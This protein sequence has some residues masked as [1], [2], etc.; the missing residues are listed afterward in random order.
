MDRVKQQLEQLRGQLSGLTPS[1]RMLVGTLLAVIA[2]TV[3]W[4]VRHAADGEMM[5]LLDQPLTADQAGVIR[6]HLRGEGI[7]FQEV[8]GKI[9]VP[10]T[11]HAEAMGVVSFNR[12][13]PSD[14]TQHFAKAL[15]Q[16]GSF[17]PRA[18]IDGTLLHA[19]ERSLAATIGRWPGVRQVEVHLNANYKRQIGGD[20]LPTAGVNVTSDGSLD[21]RSRVADAAA[22]MIAGAIPM[23]KPSAV[24]VII[25]GMAVDTNSDDGLAGGSRLLALKEQA[26][27]AWEQRLRQHYQ[28][29]PQL[30]VTVNVEVDDQVKRSTATTIDPE[31]KLIVPLETRTESDTTESASADAGGEG[32]FVPNAVLGM[33]ATAVAA[34]GGSTSRDVEETTNHVEVGR[35]RMETFSKGGQARPVSCSLSLPLSYVTQ[36][37]QGR[38]PSAGEP[39]VEVLR[40]YEQEVIASFKQ[41]VAA[42]LNLPSD[43]GV[44]VNTYADAGGVTSQAAGMLGA[45][46]LPIAATSAEGGAGISRLVT[47][48]GRPA[49]VL[50]LAAVALF[51]VS[52]AVKKSVPATSVPATPS[53]AELAA[54]GGGDG[55]QLVGADEGIAGEAGGADPLLVGQE[56]AEEQLQAGQMVE[57]VQSLVKENPDAAAALV[58][59]WINAA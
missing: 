31:S 52:S 37:W 50:T 36:Q 12:A 3:V 4:W 28:Y 49:A 27:Q 23:L 1:Q 30:Y 22:K 14:T 47:D 17:D 46:G 9:M 56:I 18:K 53:A 8:D 5:A 35:T 51:L 39:A 16:I 33:S 13:L 29:V 19:R 45:D 25:D 55:V 57:Q 58:R 34:G 26:E 7:E 54:W 10:A 38:N 48:Y 32:G 15:G 24:T 44:M 41:T 20:I 42:L 40:A 11:R 43:A 21:D 6:Q 59:R 2:V